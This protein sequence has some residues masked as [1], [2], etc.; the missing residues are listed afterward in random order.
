MRRL[1]RQISSM[2]MIL[3]LIAALATSFVLSSQL[4]GGPDDAS[5][6][7]GTEVFG[8]DDVPLTSPGPLPDAPVALVIAVSVLLASAPI[9]VSFVL[10]HRAGK[11]PKPSE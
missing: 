7:S 5:A 9:A 2:I 4:S 3:A 11:Q 6:P 8:Q 10:E 1:H